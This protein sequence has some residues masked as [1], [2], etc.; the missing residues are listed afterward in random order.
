MLARAPRLPEAR[1]LEAAMTRFCCL[2]NAIKFSRAG[3]QPSGVYQCSHLCSH[4]RLKRCSA[5]IYYSALWILCDKRDER[6][7]RTSSVLLF[8]PP[9][10]ASHPNKPLVKS[11][12]EVKSL[13]H[14]R[15]KGDIE[16]LRSDTP[17]KKT[18]LCSQG[19]S[20]CACPVALSEY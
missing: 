3:G 17:Q 7:I 20:R 12:H 14:V 15:Q 11:S 6:G 1:D 8:R 2:Q 13:Q 16:D 10:H 19:A 9:S 18:C 5:C 4:W